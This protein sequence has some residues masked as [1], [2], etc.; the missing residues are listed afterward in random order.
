MDCPVLYTVH[1][2]NYYIVVAIQKNNQLLHGAPCGAGSCVR[3]SN[4]HQGKMSK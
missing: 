1:T 2:S 4:I 3:I